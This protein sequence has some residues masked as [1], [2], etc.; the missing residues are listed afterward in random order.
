MYSSLFNSIST[1]N[2]SKLAPKESPEDFIWLR[3]DL[4]FFPSFFIFAL[5]WKRIPLPGSLC[6]LIVTQVRG[7][8]QPTELQPFCAAQVNK[9]TD[10]S[11]HDVG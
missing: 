3:W 10:N 9:V 6:G 4:E 7:S 11:G 8:E 2:H 1:D 5:K